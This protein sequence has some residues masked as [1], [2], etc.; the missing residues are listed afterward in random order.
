MITASISETIC[1]NVNENSYAV[2]RGDD[3]FYSII[4]QDK[5]AP[6]KRCNQIAEIQIIKENN[7]ANC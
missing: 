3:K 4:E 2:D 5:E 1:N 7:G 6:L